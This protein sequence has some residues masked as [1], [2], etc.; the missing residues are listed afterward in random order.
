M[1]KGDC[2]AGYAVSVKLQYV[3][4]GKQLLEDNIIPLYCKQWGYL[5]LY[6]AMKEKR[7]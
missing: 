1:E 5:E 2:L 4:K 7:E 3:S 6:R